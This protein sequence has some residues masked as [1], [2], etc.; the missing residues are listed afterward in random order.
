MLYIWILYLRWNGTLLLLVRNFDYRDWGG[1]VAHVRERL[2][3]VSNLGWKEWTRLL[4]ETTTDP[5]LVLV[6]LSAV[7]PLLSEPWPTPCGITCKSTNAHL[8][9]RCHL[10][11]L[12][13]VLLR[14]NREPS[15]RPAQR[16]AR[17]QGTSVDTKSSM[18][19]A[20]SRKSLGQWLS[21]RLTLDS[22]SRPRARAP[23]PSAPSFSHLASRSP[24]AL[25]MDGKM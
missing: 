21:S 11:G 20:A 13:C 16:T 5:D 18:A 15:D 7:P 8:R 19:S 9:E 25:T 6:E 24:T 22:P 10:L 12:W 17:S 14:N 1:G 4:R 23:S 2:A 3:A